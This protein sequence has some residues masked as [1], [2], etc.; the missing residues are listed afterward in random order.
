MLLKEKGATQQKTGFV[1]AAVTWGRVLSVYT[2]ISPEGSGK[3]TPA[4]GLR[5][6][7]RRKVGWSIKAIMLLVESHEVCLWTLP[8]GLKFFRKG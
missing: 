1:L 7:Q 3:S 5:L 6:P 2:L 4:L 8:S